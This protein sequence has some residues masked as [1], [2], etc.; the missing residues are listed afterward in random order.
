VSQNMLSPC[1]VDSVSSPFSAGPPLENSDPWCSS[2]SFWLPLENEMPQ[3][4]VTLAR[5]VFSTRR[6]SPELE[7]GCSLEVL[8]VTFAVSAPLRR[9]F[10]T[11]SHIPSRRQEFYAPSSRSAFVFKTIAPSSVDQSLE[12]SRRLTFEDLLSQLFFDS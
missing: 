3:S 2:S 10:S 9:R 12:P 7:V 8:F 1:Q 5:F 11:K 6:V 4:H